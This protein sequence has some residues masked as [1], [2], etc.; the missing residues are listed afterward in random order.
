MKKKTIILIFSAIA[1]III[2]GHLLSTGEKYCHSDF[3]SND[4]QYEVCYSEYNF[5]K[6]LKYQHRGKI[7]IN[8]KLKNSTLYT[9]HNQSY[10]SFFGTI[11]V[12]WS[13]DSV[14]LVGNVT[15][16]SFKLPR[17]LNINS[18]SDKHLSK[19]PLIDKLSDTYDFNKDGILD[20]HSLA[21]DDSGSF[22]ILFLMNKDG[23]YRT[24][25]SD[26]IK[27]NETLKLIRLNNYNE[28]EVV[29]KEDKRNLK[30]ERV[31][32]LAFDLQTD[33]LLIIDDVIKLKNK[34]N[35]T[36]IIQGGITKTPLTK[37]YN[38]SL[39]EKI[40][41]IRQKYYYYKEK[42][43]T[44]EE[45]YEEHYPK[46]YLE[47]LS[48][49]DSINHY[50]TVALKSQE[51]NLS[52]FV[53]YH[54]VYHREL[55]NNAS[56]SVDEEGT[57]TL[58]NLKNLE[59]KGNNTIFSNFSTD[60]ALLSI[61]ESSN[62]KIEDIK[63]YHDVAEGSCDAPVLELSNSEAITSTRLILDG[64]GLVGLSMYNSSGSLN[65]SEIT[66]CWLSALEVRKN[67]NL[68][69]IQTAIK[70]NGASDILAIRDS[71]ITFTNCTIKNNAV[72]MFFDKDDS[73]KIWIDAS[74]I[75][76]NF[77]EE[78]LTPKKYGNKH[79]NNSANYFE[80][81]TNLNTTLHFFK[82][83]NSA[84]PDYK[85]FVSISNLKEQLKITPLTNGT[86]NTYNDIAYYCE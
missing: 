34:Q 67:S 47:T 51:Y 5:S 23:S 24:I 9:L 49:L 37:E 64:S 25:Q 26:Y 73:S 29:F 74:S 14:H 65:D 61:K 2:V 40:K 57:I 45:E 38:F 54:G 60:G 82:Q 8:D 10:N 72:E 79:F 66:N 75:Y 36:E 80:L 70:N 85:R 78:K 46:E 16:K 76:D 22:F 3:I 55:E 86:V 77:S 19:I 69:I 21:Y 83:L 13:I 81:L 50:S 62:I 84:N 68:E 33:D 52:K 42:E 31:V 59:I 71:E 12:E 41:K 35:N 56:V 6:Y 27:N 15:H 43:N 39:P 17:K 18:V 58:T 53:R 32:K 11:D 4:N 63:M 7:T 44:E 20:K 28:I 1:L 30:W 48:F